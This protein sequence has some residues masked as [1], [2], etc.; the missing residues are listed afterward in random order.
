MD[1]LI[2]HLSAREILLFL[3]NCE[4]LIFACAEFAESILHKCPDL[5]ILA[6]SREVLGITGEASWTVPPLSMPHQHPWKNPAGGQ[7]A[8]Q[9]YEDFESVKLF[10]DRAKTVYQDFRL[11]TENGAWVAEICRRL[12]GMPLAIEL[13]AARVRD[14]TVQQIAQRLDERFRLLTAG[15]RTAPPRQQTLLS[16]LDWSYALLSEQEQKVL[17]R[18]SVCAGSVTLETAESLCAGEGIQSSEVGDALFRLVS[19]SLVIADKPESGQSRFLPRYHLLET[20]RQYAFERLAA[21]AEMEEAKN[22]HLNY[23]LQWAEAAEPHLSGPQ[24]LLWLELYESEHDNLRAALD[25]CKADKS[26]AKEGLRLVNACS[27]FWRLRGYLSEGRTHIANAL[28][29]LPDQKDTEALAHAL[30]WSA[31]LAYLQSDYPATRSLGEQ[32]LELWRELDPP[33]KSKLADTLDLLGELA[34][35]EGD[36]ATAPSYFIEALEIFRKLEDP[37]GIGDMLMQLGW[38]YM[39]MGD[40]EQAAPLMEE[41]LQLFREIR[42]VSLIGFALG[43]LG[44]LAIRQGQYERAITFLE[45]SLAIRKQHGHK[46]GVGATLGSL[47]WIALQ[48]QDIKQMKALLGESLSVRI[49][50]GDQGG[51]AWCLEKLAEA[52]YDQSRFDEAAKIF[53]H[54]Q[55]LRAPIGSVIDP[56]D[57][58]EY[59]R[60]ISEL[61]RA[62]GKDAFAGLWAAGA[63]MR[64]EEVVKCALSDR[65]TEPIPTEKEKFGGLTAREREVAALIAQGKSNREIARAMTVGTKT[66]ETYVTRILNKLGFE[67]RVQIATWAVEKRLISTV[68]DSGT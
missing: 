7:E 8:V 35:E 37:R 64:L 2:S 6:T 25:W 65:A 13:A 60:I 20:I 47:G 67:S 39:R 9:Y 45:E 17:Q 48:Q 4:H 12:D 10:V 1:I 61:R 54:A 57:Q 19:K 33:D 32:S 40:Y 66:V 26:R 43:G 5:K 22:R 14:L 34:T 24:Q 42:H 15:S 3:D 56:A 38:A 31:S 30:F 59:D 58:P 50:I 23:F 27:H 52:K 28:S 29:Q 21:S 51:I 68:H 53:G 55:V 18:L 62:L 36:Y 49:E 16:T 44:E 63:A 11:T 46:W 41:S